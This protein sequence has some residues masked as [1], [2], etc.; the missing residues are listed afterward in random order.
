MRKYRDVPP[1]GP[2]FGSVMPFDGQRHAKNPVT[3]RG[4]VP[5]DTALVT[6]FPPSKHRRPLWPP[7]VVYMDGGTHSR[8]LVR[9]YT[10][11]SFAGDTPG[12][13]SSTAAQ[14]SAIRSTQPKYISSYDPGVNG[15]NGKYSFPPESAV[16][17]SGAEL[18]LTPPILSSK[19]KGAVKGH[20]NSDVSAR[21]ASIG[22]HLYIPELMGMRQT[23]TGNR[24]SPGNGRRWT[25]GVSLPR[26]VVPCFY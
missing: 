4:S 16:L 11:P 26:S 13:S 7:Q 12:P 1:S 8:Q 21:T 18:T 2:E 23:S 10:V 14:Q 20:S 25:G 6:I 3:N 17:L 22:S 24:C 15:V 5:G 19:A 9:P